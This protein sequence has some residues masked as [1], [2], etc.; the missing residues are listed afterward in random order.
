MTFFIFNCSSNQGSFFGVT[1]EPTGARL[2]STACVKGKWEPFKK[3]EKSGKPRIAFDET[4]AKA[5]IEKQGYYLFRVENRFTES[6]VKN[7]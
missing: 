6:V 1:D 2:P 7:G 4:T 5:E 3:I